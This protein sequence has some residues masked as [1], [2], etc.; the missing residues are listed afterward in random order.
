[1]EFADGGT[2]IY[3]LKISNKIFPISFRIFL[4]HIFEIFRW[5]DDISPV[6]EEDAERQRQVTRNKRERW[7]NGT[8]M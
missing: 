1:M 4:K 7:Q 6:W 2:L 8:R 5:L 3:I